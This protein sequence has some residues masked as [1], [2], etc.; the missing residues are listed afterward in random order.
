MRGWI[1]SLIR[2]PAPG[3]VGYGTFY[4]PGFKSEFVNG[5]EIIWNAVCPA[6]PGG[7][8]NNYLYIT[9]TN[10]SSMGVEAFIFYDGANQVAFRIYDWARPESE[11]WQ[12]NMPFEAITPYLQAQIYY[13]Q[14]Y[15]IISIWNATK[16]T[17]NNSWSNSV[18]LYDYT[19]SNWALIYRYDYTATDNAQ[20]Q[21]YVGSWG[22]IVET[23]QTLYQGTNPMGALSVSLRNADANSSWSAWGALSNLQS[24][25]RVDNVGF[26]VEK[27]DPNFDW[28]I[29]S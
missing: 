28:I 6:M 18:Y 11:R 1:L 2:L 22:P 16:K 17:G 26:H 7:N 14:L 25:L 8:V 5:T 27:L 4:S 12:T 23:F 3:G 10:R 21:G 15:P 19:K 13:G 9:A 20:K 24:T 29:S